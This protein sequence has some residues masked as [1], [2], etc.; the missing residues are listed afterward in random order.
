MPLARC[1]PRGDR[2]GSRQRG[3][4]SERVQAFLAQIGVAG[5]ARCPYHE[6][7]WATAADFVSEQFESRVYDSEQIITA[8]RAVGVEATAIEGIWEFFREPV[9]INGKSLGNGQHRSCAL[10]VA[11]G[12]TCPVER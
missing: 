10:R 3:R 8:A 5:I 6:V 2:G 11:G 12:K 7:D 4:S 1:A 9:W